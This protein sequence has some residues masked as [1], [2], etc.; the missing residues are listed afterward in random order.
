M[1]RATVADLSDPSKAAAAGHGRVIS[2]PRPSAPSAPPLRLSS[3]VPFSPFYRF[4]ALQTIPPSPRRP[5]PL[6]PTARATCPR[7]PCHHSSP[8]APP[9]PSLSVLPRNHGPI[10]SNGSARRLSGLRGRG[11]P[12]ARSCSRG[13]LP[14]GRSC[15]HQRSPPGGGLPKSMRGRLR[16]AHPAFASVTFLELP[17]LQTADP[18][19]PS[20]T[21]RYLPENGWNVYRHGE[22]DILFFD[23]PRPQA[24]DA[25]GKLPVQARTL[26][27]AS[28]AASSSSAA[29]LVVLVAMSP[30]RT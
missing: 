29:A 28:P 12:C 6:F 4:V 18:A 17:S 25:N 2:C 1:T 21:H 14:A 13:S 7:P 15:P 16:S 24:L 3:R 20:D 27:L 30:Q 22:S 23:R 10:A 9:W 26:P 5:A 11:T 19:C 8:P